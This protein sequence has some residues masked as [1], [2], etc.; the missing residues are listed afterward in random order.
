[1]SGSRFWIPDSE[2][3][4]PNTG[5]KIQD[6]R[7]EIQDSRLKIRELSFNSKITTPPSHRDFLCIMRM[8]DFQWQNLS[9]L[10]KV[11]FDGALILA[12]CRLPTTN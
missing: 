3:R 6:S 11:L 4:T 9:K 7:F 2:F 12:N 8:G 1:V 10:R 5:F